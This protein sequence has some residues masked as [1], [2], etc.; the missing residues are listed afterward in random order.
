VVVV[1]VVVVG[2][3]P[4]GGVGSGAPVDGGVEGGAVSCVGPAPGTTASLRGGGGPNVVPG[5]A[6][7]VPGALAVAPVVVLAA[8]VATG[9]ET[10]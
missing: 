6:T 9:P 3:G 10:A 4:T 7:V 5:G 8:P 2:T 1:V